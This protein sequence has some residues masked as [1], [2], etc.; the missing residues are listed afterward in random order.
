MSA[1]NPY[2]PPTANV[3]D[4]SSDSDT[5]EQAGRGARLGAALLDG[6]IMSLIIYVP[7]VIA[8]VA[9]GIFSGGVGADPFALFFG[10]V[11]YALLAGAVVWG[12]ITLILVKRYSAT[13]GKKLVG[14]KVVRADGSHASLGRIFWM[15]N[16]VNTLP[17][18]IPIVGYFYWLVDALFIF[19]ESRQ[20]LHDKI[21]DT[22]VVKA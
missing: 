1:A 18:L 2:A 10:P 20:C 8:G 7:A 22:I 11:G 19:S 9:T 4:N 17:S 21:A 3:V 16:F 13:I 14:I 6:L 5:I 12:A 15:R